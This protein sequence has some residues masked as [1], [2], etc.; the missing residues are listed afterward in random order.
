MNK[1]QTKTNTHSIF[2]QTW[3]PVIIM[4][5]WLE[6]A[7]FDN[8]LHSA[9]GHLSFERLRGHDAFDLHGQIC[10]VILLE[11]I[12]KALVQESLQ[13]FS[14]SFKSHK[15]TTMRWFCSLITTPGRL[16]QIKWQQDFRWI[17]YILQMGGFFW[18][19]FSCLTHLKEILEWFSKSDKRVLRFAVDM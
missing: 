16:P 19:S 17:W 12:W 6:N 11:H 3:Q 10:I 1:Y 7:D 2:N 8:V 5:C 15:M 4:H 18:V 13:Q 9:K 14:H